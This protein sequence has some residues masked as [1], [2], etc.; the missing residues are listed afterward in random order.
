VGFCWMLCLSIY[1]VHPSDNLLNF[2][3]VLDRQNVI[4]ALGAIK[5]NSCYETHGRRGC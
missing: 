1:R 5:E 2:I 4:A 3:A